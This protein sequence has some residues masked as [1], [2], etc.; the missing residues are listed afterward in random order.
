[1]TGSQP[2]APKDSLDRHATQPS[3]Q[4]GTSDLWTEVHTEV[5]SQLAILE[6]EVRRR[7][8]AARATSGRTKGSR[9]F[10][11][12]YRTFAIPDSRLDPVVAGVLFRPADRGVAVEADVSGE[13][14]GDCISPAFSATVANSKE[15]LLTTAR[16]LAQ[17]LL[18]SADVI[19]AALEDSSRKAE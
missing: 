2:V 10:L 6:G 3:N 11:F 13:Y 12:S 14:T 5:Q 7:V 17:R 8:P 15:E 16:Q 9:F 1:M 18:E 4:D 19:A